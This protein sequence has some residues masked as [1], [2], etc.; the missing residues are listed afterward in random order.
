MVSNFAIEDI[1]I[2]GDGTQT[3]DFCYVDDPIEAM[4]HVMDTPDDLTG[5]LNIRN[6]QEFTM[7]EL[8][9]HVVGADQVKRVSYFSNR[10]LPM[11]PNNVSQT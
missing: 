3:R 7:L 5:P 11:T 8:A 6:P 9:E 2:Y 10:R 4:I 1:M